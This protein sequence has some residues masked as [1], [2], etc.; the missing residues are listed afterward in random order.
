MS[1][2]E[3]QEQQG[4]AWLHNMQMMNT[5]ISQMKEIPI[6]P[7]EEVKEQNALLKV[8]F[9]EEG[10]VLTYIEG[11]DE[12]YRG[13]PY[14][15]FVEKIDT[16]KKIVRT[17]LSGTYH[18]L[19]RRPKIAL[20]TILPA[21]WLIRPVIR[22]SVYVFYRMIERFKIKTIR[23]SQPIQELHRILSLEPKKDSPKFRRQ[24]RDLICMTAEFDNAYRFRMQDIL[25][26][27]D[28]EA[29]KQ[30]PIKEILRLFEILQG[31]E[32]TQEIRDTWKLVKFFITY[33]LR[34]D[35]ELLSILTTALSGLNKKE[36]KLSKEDKVFCK[37]RKD[38]KFGF[39]DNNK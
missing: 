28:K 39:L 9:P 20:I 17:T 36:F 5:V 21:L 24:L 11:Y 8:E 37:P 23:Y 4:R 18:E 35:K 13:F 7:S 1:E 6:L 12:P 10:G 15:E 16:M 14:A 38:Y 34:F 30:N 31:R 22:I 32:K 29:L 2:N 27:L 3:Q 19:K 25:V 26:N 33:Y